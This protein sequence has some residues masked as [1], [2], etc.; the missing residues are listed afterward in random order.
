MKYLKIII[1]VTVVLMFTAQAA[2]QTQESRET[3]EREV[4]VRKMHE[5]EAEVQR[6]MYDAE[7]R[8][9]EAARQ[10]AE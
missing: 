3:Q 7:S 5:R 2:A 8:M 4:E 9:A 10:I 1:S 6:K